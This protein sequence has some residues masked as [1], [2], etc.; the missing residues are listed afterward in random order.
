MHNQ[1]RKK[2]YILFDLT[3]GILQLA[4][5]P[6]KSLVEPI[7]TCCTCCLDVPIPIAEA[8][9]TK[10]VCDLSSIHCIGKIL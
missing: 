10:L 6:I 9:K 3:I 4:G 2:V 7:P 5:E 1:K 8:V